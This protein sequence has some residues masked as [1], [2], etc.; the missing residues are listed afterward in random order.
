MPFRVMWRFDP[1]QRVRPGKRSQR[2]DV[3][4]QAIIDE[5]LKELLDDQD[6]EEEM[7]NYV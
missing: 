5:E 6:D 4:Q 1:V 7:Y 2:M 3:N